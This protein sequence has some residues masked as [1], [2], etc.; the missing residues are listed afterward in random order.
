MPPDRG[1]MN[2][3]MSGVKGIKKRITYALT[4]NADGS[5][6]LP[7]LIIGKAEKPRAFKKKTGKQLGFLYRNNAKAWMT[8]P[9]YQEWLRDVDRDMRRQKRQILLLQ[10][11]FKGHTVPD[12]I[13]NVRVEFFR[14][15]LTAHV[16]PMDAG[17]IRCFKSHY[18]RLTMQRALDRYDTDI[19]PSKIYDIDQ[20]ESMRLADLAWKT[21]SSDTIANC[22]HKSGILPTTAAYAAFLD[23]LCAEADDGSRGLIETLDELQSRGAL[24]QNNRLT[25]DDL[26]DIP[27]ERVVED[28]TDEEIVEAVQKMRE[29]QAD[30]EINGGDDDHGDISDVPKITRREALEAVLKLRSYLADVEGPFA[31]QLEVG[32]AKFGRETRMEETNSLIPTAI[33]DFFT[34][35]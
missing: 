19:S 16:Q 22:W 4:T 1:L 15:N 13:T 24:Q 9:L 10:D 29:C 23:E 21:V 30:K 32:L 25:I 8:T 28:A 7:P 11:N 26:V 34:P 14:P 12:G 6:K 5:Q 18:R 20:L 2:Q 17:I 27:E 33:T 3:R 35:K 31:R